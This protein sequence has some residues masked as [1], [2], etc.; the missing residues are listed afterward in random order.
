MTEN[1]LLPFALPAV[2]RK[3]V[4]AAFDGGRITSDGGVV[5]LAEAERRLGLV[6]RLAAVIADGR[7][8]AR[9]IHRLPDILRARILAIACGWEDADDLDTLRSDPAFKL[10]CALIRRSSWPAD[11]YPTVG[12]TCARSRP[13]RAGR[14]RRPCARSFA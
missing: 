11:G 4:M 5:L 13:C 9:V 7:D 14:M 3:K 12:G 10:A 6:D 2:H 1:S 8:P